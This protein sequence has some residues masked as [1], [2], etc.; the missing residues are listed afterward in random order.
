MLRALTEKP[1]YFGATMASREG[2]RA[3]KDTS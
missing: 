3:P 1:A 2:L